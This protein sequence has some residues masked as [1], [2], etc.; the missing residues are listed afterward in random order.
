MIREV[1]IPK[2]KARFAD[3]GFQE[4]SENNAIGY[5]PAAHYQVG[6]LA[7]FDDGDEAT[8]YIGQITHLHIDSEESEGHRAEE[9]IANEVISFLEELF[10]DKLMIWKSKTTGADGVFPLAN[11][12]AFSGVDSSDSTFFWSGPVRKPKLAG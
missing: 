7:I 4:R 11:V 6:D 8:I 10:A 1:L 3:R 5:F 12:A 2:L 9:E